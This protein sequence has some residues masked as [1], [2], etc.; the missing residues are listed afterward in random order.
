MAVARRPPASPSYGTYYAKRMVRA[1]T[2]RLP[3][4]AL[5]LYDTT[6]LRTTIASHR[7]GGGGSG[8]AK[9][10]PGVACGRDSSE[11]GCC[12]HCCA[13]A[14]D[15]FQRHCPW[16]GGAPPPWSGGLQ[17]LSY[18]HVDVPTLGGAGVRKC[19]ALSF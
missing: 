5:A 4:E 1:V 18:M 7:L 6:L 9:S 3:S 12:H 10:A 19:A 13:R 2:A 16:G 15:G 8:R 11:A 14:M 17:P